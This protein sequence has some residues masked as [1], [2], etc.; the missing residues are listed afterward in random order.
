M[1]VR[2]HAELN[3]MRSH[4]I[5]C[6]DSSSN[7]RNKYKFEIPIERDSIEEK[8]MTGNGSGAPAAS[9]GG[10]LFTPTQ[11]PHRLQNQ[12][13]QAHRGKTTFSFVVINTCLFIKY[14]S[15]RPQTK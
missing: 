14:V 9:R 2:I 15:K 3:S 1:W 4:V 13:A 8:W 6:P 12:H 5:P 11:D 10:H 7:T